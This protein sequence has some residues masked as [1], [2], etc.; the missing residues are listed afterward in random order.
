MRTAYADRRSL[1]IDGPCDR[2]ARRASARQTTT[3][4]AAPDRPRLRLLL[5]R[6]TSRG[7][8][9]IGRLLTAASFR[10]RP[11]A[12]APISWPVGRRRGSE[13]GR[14]GE[15]CHRSDAEQTACAVATAALI[16][17]QAVR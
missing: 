2:Y 16:A 3:Q 1:G 6:T 9:R 5:P 11:E 14:R 12:A 7:V 10:R 4:T 17:R 13:R 15:C 8:G